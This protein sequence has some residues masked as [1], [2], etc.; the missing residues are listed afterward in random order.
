MVAHLK[1][2]PPRRRRPK[3]RLPRLVLT[4]ALALGRITQPHHLQTGGLPYGGSRSMGIRES[5]RCLSLGH[6]TRF[7][8]LGGER[9]A[10][11]LGLLS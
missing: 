6:S 2:C 5:R 9:R 3:S 10:R 4:R 1:L 7:G 8:Q 11:C